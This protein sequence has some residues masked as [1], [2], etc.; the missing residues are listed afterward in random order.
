[1][2]AMGWSA[3]TGPWTPLAAVH[4]LMYPELIESNVV[5]TNASGVH[6]PVVAEHAIAVMLALAKRLPQAMQ[7]QARKIWSQ[8]L[9]WNESPRP[10][11]VAGGAPAWGGQGRTG[12]A[13]PAPPPA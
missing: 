10:R 8:E 3:T 4:Q 5:L 7:Y 13:R 2:G 6:G 9:L 1:M 11:E 12:R